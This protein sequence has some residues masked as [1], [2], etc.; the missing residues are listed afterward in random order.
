MPGYVK[1][2]LLQ[3]Q[4]AIPKQPHY[5]PSKFTPPTYGAKQQ[6]TRELDTT[7]ELSKK[8]L[9]QVNGKFLYY[10][11][12]IDGTMLHALKELASHELLS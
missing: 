1:K 10:A 4:Y 12:A 6:L 3:F 9:Q 11:H 5:A 2:A 8:L 7:P